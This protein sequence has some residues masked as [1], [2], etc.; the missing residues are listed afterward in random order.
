MLDGPSGGKPVSKETIS[1]DDS[2]VNEAKIIKTVHQYYELRLKI[3]FKFT[4]SVG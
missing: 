4:V 2:T 3:K 1:D